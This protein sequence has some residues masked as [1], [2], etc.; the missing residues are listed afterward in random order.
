MLVAAL[1]PPGNRVVCLSKLDED[2]IVDGKAFRLGMNEFIDGFFPNGQAFLREFAL[3]PFPK[4]VYEIDGVAVEKTLFMPQG[5]NAVAAVYTLVNKNS[6][7]L[8][9][10]VFPLLSWRHFHDVIDSDSSLLEMRQKLGTRRIEFT[11]NNPSATAVLAISNGNFVEKSNIV[12]RLLYREEAFRGESSL[13]DCYQPGYFE[14]SAQGNATTEFAVVAAV[15]QNP[16]ECNAVL[17]SVGT[18]TVNV[19]KSLEAEIKR[20]TTHL[21]SFYDAQNRVPVNDWLSWAL[22]A[23]DSF[24]VRG[25]G[26]MRSVIAGYHWF[27]TWGRDTCISLPGLLL[28]TGRFGD[29]EKVLVSF[30]RFVKNGLIPNFLPENSD[31]PAYNSVDASLWYVNAVLQYVKYTGDFRFVE[32][33]LWQALAKIVESYERGTSHGI[34]LDS[35][36]LIAH[37]AG[38]TWMDAKVDGE[39]VTPRLGKAVEVQALWF[40]AL[41]TVQ[42]LA[43]RLGHRTFAW[44]C[45]DMAGRAR[46]TFDRKFWN[47]EKQCL[48]DVVDPSGDDASLRPNQIVAAALDFPVLYPDKAESV[49]DVVQRELFASYGLRTLVRSDVHYHGKYVGDRQS[50]DRAYHNGTAWPWLLGPFI[51][52]FVN[53]K[54]AELETREFALKNFIQPLFAEKLFAAGLGVVSEVFDGDPPHRS[55]GCISQAWSVAEPLR[56]YVEDVLQIRPPYEQK[57]LHAGAHLE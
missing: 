25:V 44:R 10:H 12:R 4:F 11:F 23:A 36:G 15:D 50:R 57:V 21:A 3:A 39:A 52:A 33:N 31:E 22:L 18:D 47:P 27:G 29:A 5:R 55:G 30:G 46:G 19:K 7:D 43:A 49:V 28:V 26:D 17:N 1:H 42:L 54:G 35:D 13:D 2:I 53:V 56:A 38:L 16:S 8:Q 40:N 9:V 6:R 34:H 51:K 41:R 24:L 32:E 37:G 48:F 14:I 45:S 20:R